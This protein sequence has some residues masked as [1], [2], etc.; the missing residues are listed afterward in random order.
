M[1]DLKIAPPEIEGYRYVRATSW[2]W[3]TLLFA[4]AAVLFVVGP[5]EVLLPFAI[6][7]VQRTGGIGAVL[8]GLLMLMY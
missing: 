8:Q 1:A 6:Q 3:A 5:L 2:L 7:W 4:L